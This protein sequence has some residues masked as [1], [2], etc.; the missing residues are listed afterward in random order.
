MFF[1]KFK[2]DFSAN[3]GA[4]CAI[5]LWIIISETSLD[6]KQVFSFKWIVRGPEMCK[7]FEHE[8]YEIVDPLL[9]KIIKC[10][11][12]YTIT[13]SRIDELKKVINSKMSKMHAFDL[14]IFPKFAQHR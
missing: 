6:M 8:S 3:H 14:S 10:K 7:S 9:I 5:A 11:G 13:V 1:I 4:L 2:N 12:A